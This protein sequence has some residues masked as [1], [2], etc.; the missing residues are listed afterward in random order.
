MGALPVDFWLHTVPN[1]A[2][3]TSVPDGQ[4]DMR[5][6]RPLGSV[7]PFEVLLLNLCPRQ[8]E[9]SERRSLSDTEPQ[10]TFHGLAVS[11]AGQ[12]Q[13]SIVNQI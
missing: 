3:P 11:L 5:C 12:L 8:A 13:G 9:K 2:T 1:H 4:P 7:L 10:A 6:H